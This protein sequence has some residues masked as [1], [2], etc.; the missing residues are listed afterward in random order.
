MNLIYGNPDELNVS[1]A[2]KDY[3]QFHVVM[4]VPE[5]GNYRFSNCMVN[6][7]DKRVDKETVSTYV[8]FGEDVFDPEEFAVAC[9]EYY[10]E[11]FWGGYHEMI[12]AE[13]AKNRIKEYLN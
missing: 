12:D 2:E 1:L 3:K 5:H 4:I 6:I 7:N 10:G 8:G 9:V 11:R 13:E